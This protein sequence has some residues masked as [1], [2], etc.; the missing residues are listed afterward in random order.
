MKL[1]P[2]L[3]A[4]CLIATAAYGQGVEVAPLTAPD[5]FSG[6]ARDTGVGADLWKG[7]SVQL[8][9]RVLPTIGGKPL[10]PA[11]R[12]LAVRL[13]STGAN[14]PEGAGEDRALAA[15]RGRALLA[16]GEPVLANGS[17]E[18]IPNP[19][20][21]PALAE[22]VAETALL[23]GADDRA[24]RTE[25]AVTV[26]RGEAYWLR[27][28]A[29]CQ[30]IG[31]QTDA[32]QLTLTLAQEKARDAVFGRLMT[33]LLVGSDPGAP[34]ARNGLEAA[35][36]R[37]LNLALPTPVA[38]EAPTSLVGPAGLQ[39]T[40]GPCTL[41]WAALSDTADGADRDEIFAGAGKSTT[42]PGRLA[43]LQVAADRRL[44]G[45][46]GLIAVAIL[47]DAPKTG[48]TPHDRAAVIRALV[49]VGL[50]EDARFLATEGALQ[51]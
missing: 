37:R 11:G 27:L 42:A 4:A 31:G 35:L 24:C 30:A 29:F 40:G 43:A 49:R 13:L 34:S 21:D 15:A 7:A 33:A 25:Q 28:R 20:A 17:V 3:L 16:L 2:P 51:P 12:A 45:E 32:A 48:L 50:I 47:Q 26:G 46:T 41:Y 44:V 19:T 1:L 5:V 10:T 22:I 8:L 39:C 38:P 36:S 18:R 23:T 9:R 14:A 6:G